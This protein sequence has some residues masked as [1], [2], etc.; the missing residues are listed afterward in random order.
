[1]SIADKVAIK[2]SGL[3]HL[4]LILTSTVYVEQMALVTGL[5]ELFARDEIRKNQQR[6]QFQEVREAFLRYILKIDA[7][8]LTVP[9]NQLYAQIGKGRAQIEVLASQRRSIN[10]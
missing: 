8:R 1:L 9:S 6:G 2:D 10:R 4:E 3:A 7:G 5:N